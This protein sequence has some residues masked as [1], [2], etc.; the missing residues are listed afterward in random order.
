MQLIR[1]AVSQK[2]DV[3]IDMKNMKVSF[4]PTLTLLRSQYFVRLRNRPHPEL[5]V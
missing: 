5:V 2:P 1:Q 3:Y 4:N